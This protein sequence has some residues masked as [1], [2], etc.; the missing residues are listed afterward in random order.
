MNDIYE[1]ISRNALMQ[2]PLEALY[3]CI[4]NPVVGNPTQLMIEAAF[5]DLGFPARYLTCK[6][7]SKELGAAVAGIRAL[8]FAGANVTAPHKVAVMEFLDDLTISA[9]LSGTVNCIY[10]QGGK[11]VGDNT[12][13]KGFLQSIQETTTTKGMRVLVFGAGGA[14]RAIITELALHGVKEIH[15]ANRTEAKAQQIVNALENKVATRLQTVV[16]HPG[17]TIGYGYDLIVQGTSVGLFNA[18]QMLD[19]RWEKG[20]HTGQFAADVVFNPVDTA[21]LQRADEAGARAIDGLGMLVNQGAIALT[22]WTGKTANRTVMR[23]ALE[24][25]FGS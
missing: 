23:K 25:A 2:G 3:C 1:K 11:L 10:N 4:G 24:I 13:G 8:G 17:F 14:S 5:R 18:L 20:S 9:R 15:I 22:Q 19:V 12:D 21:F 7:E 6:V 16:L